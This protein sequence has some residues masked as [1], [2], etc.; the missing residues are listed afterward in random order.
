MRRT[1]LGA[2]GE[3]ALVAAVEGHGL[4]AELGEARH[5]GG[6]G[7]HAEWGR[8]LGLW[9]GYVGACVWVLLGEAVEDGGCGFDGRVR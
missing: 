7:V 6:A 2:Q 4:V 1:R 9:R 5:G 8:G 3:H